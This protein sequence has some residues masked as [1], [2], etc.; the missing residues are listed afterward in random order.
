MTD[1]GSNMTWLI[2]F[3]LRFRYHF[4]EWNVTFPTYA[5]NDFIEALMLLNLVPQT[6]HSWPFDDW[7]SRMCLNWIPLRIQVCPKKGINPNQSYCWGRDWYHQTYENS[8]RV[9]ILRVLCFLLVTWSPSQPLKSTPQKKTVSFHQQVWKRI[10]KSRQWGFDVDEGIVM[11][12]TNSSLLKQYR[13]NL[14]KNAVADIVTNLYICHFCLLLF[15]G[16]P[17]FSII[18][19]SQ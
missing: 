12:W 3:V 9:W 2:P 14:N 6:F 8:G 16:Q 4:W 15:F 19:K 18:A 5:E 1:V 7:T 13:G 17:L 10:L 11:L